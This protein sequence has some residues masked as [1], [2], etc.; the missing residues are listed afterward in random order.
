MN[1][2]EEVG[3]MT[4]K[5]ERTRDRRLVGVLILLGRNAVE[6]VEC[7]MTGE[8]MVV[9]NYVVMDWTRLNKQRQMMVVTEL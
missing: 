3:S 6:A 8:C 5:A 7:E 2:V 9:P 4:E 1:V